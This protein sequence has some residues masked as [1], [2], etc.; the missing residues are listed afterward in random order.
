ML[1]PLF[2]WEQ[3]KKML[4]QLEPSKPP[5]GLIHAGGGSRVT[6]L[7]VPQPL[8][9]TLSSPHNA[10]RTFNHP[11]AAPGKIP[12]EL[13][14]HGEEFAVRSSTLPRDAAPLRRE[15]RGGNNPFA[16]I[17]SN[18][19]GHTHFAFGILR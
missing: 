17:K 3:S 7:L 5:G 11:P 14:A 8:G 6:P 10:D 19:T 12:C 1:L 4:V 13:F 18:T 9:E 15:G 2:K 16:E